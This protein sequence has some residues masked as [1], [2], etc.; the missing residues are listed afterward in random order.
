M[1]GQRITGYEATEW[2][3]QILDHKVSKALLGTDLSEIEISALSQC[4]EV[5]DEV[6]D[7][8]SNLNI[9]ET[10]LKKLIL[11]EWIGGLDK[12]MNTTIVEQFATKIKK[13]S[14]LEFYKA[15]LMKDEP[16]DA[17]ADLVAQIISSV[18]GLTKIDLA[19]NMFSASATSKILTSVSSCPSIETIEDLDL[20]LSANFS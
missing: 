5:T 2:D 7:L 13:L 15:M 19:K 4:T 6:F 8:L 16:K 18:E 10:G 9:A 14:V 3:R 20:Q 11:S 17:V 1:N 12:P